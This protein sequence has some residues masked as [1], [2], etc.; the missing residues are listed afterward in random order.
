MSGKFMKGNVIRTPSGSIEIVIDV[1]DDGYTN[2]IP[3]T[4]TNCE[5]G[6]RAKT[7]VE[8]EYSYDEDNEPYKRTVYG[9]DKCELVAYTI[10]EWIIQSYTKNF[11]F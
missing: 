2:T 4:S 11:G 7:Y 5:I 10:K 9:M 8:K 3:I 6:R 1:K